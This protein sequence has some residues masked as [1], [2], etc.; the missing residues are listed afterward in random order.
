MFHERR[1]RLMVIVG[2]GS[3]AVALAFG[4]HPAYLAV[5]LVCPLMMVLMMRSM[6][7]MGGMGAEDHAGHGCEHDPTR[8]DGPDA[9]PVNESGSAQHRG[10]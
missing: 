4:V 8:P 1:T 6:G 2:I 10:H 3:I 7:G 5:L 9:T